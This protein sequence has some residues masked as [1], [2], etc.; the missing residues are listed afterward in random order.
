M[1]VALWEEGGHS[2]ASPFPRMTYHDAMERYGTD[3][4]DLRF[5]LSIDDLAGQLAGRGFRGFR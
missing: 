1:L 5:K 3:K 2:L 4:P